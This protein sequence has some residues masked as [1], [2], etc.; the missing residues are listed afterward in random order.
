MNTFRTTDNCKRI[1]I[2]YYFFGLK[3]NHTKIKKKKKLKK[4]INYCGYCAV[5][6]YMV[7]KS[8][9]GGK[10][11]NVAITIL[12]SFTLLTLQQAPGLRS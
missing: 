1:K 12:T 6:K 4:N 11:V 10:W 3:T 9:S 7:E 2:C 8:T 5:P